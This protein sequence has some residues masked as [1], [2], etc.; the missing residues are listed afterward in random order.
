LIRK[1]KLG[2]CARAANRAGFLFDVPGVIRNV[3]RA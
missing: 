1:L 3:C 2:T